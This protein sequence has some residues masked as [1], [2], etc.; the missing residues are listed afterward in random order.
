MSVSAWLG[1]GLLRF[2]V[3]HGLS[4]ASWAT[5]G[6]RTLMG[7]GTSAPVLAVLALLGIDVVV[8]RREYRLAFAVP[9]AVIASTVLT[10]GLKQIIDRARPPADLALVPSEASQT[11]QISVARLLIG[12]HGAI[13]MAH[14]VAAVTGKDQESEEVHT[15]RS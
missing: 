14:M 8:A 7:I 9:V 2:V 1:E 11:G 5:G 4:W 10:A 13:V 12:D 6:A 3:A 15:L